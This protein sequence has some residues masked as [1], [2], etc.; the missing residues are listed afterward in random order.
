MFRFVQASTGFIGLYSAQFMV[1]LTE[2]QKMA[3]NSIHVS[4]K[5]CS[6]LCD[7]DRIQNDLL[8][9]QMG[10]VEQVGYSD[11]ERGFIEVYL[12][13]NSSFHPR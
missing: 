10:T 3:Y 4:C 1:L 12:I 2:L 6:V 9:P 11:Q 7:T 5:L 13:D 8:P